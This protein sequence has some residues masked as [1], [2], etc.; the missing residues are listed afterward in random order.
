MGKLGKLPIFVI[1]L[2]AVV[3]IGGLSFGAHKMLIVPKKETLAAKEKEL[4]DLE[5]K[6][7]QLDSVKRQLAEVEQKWM[8]ANRDLQHIMETR[9]IPLSFAMP[10]E[11][12]LTI[13]YELRH[14][15]GPVLTQW[16]ES[17]GCEI[18]SGASLPAPPGSPPPPPPTGFV[19]IADNLSITVRGTLEQLE[20]LY[21]SLNQC[22]RILTVKGLS[23]K[24]EG[25]AMSATVPLTVYL[26][27]EVPPG[28][29]A[30][31]AAAPGAPGMMGPGMPGAPAM[32]G[33][34][35]APGGPA[36]GPPGPGE[37]GPR[38]EGAPAGPRLRRGAEGGEE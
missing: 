35:E 37:A 28:A 19:T 11:A 14:D 4:S 33:G 10:I 20:T 1:P 32:P 7:R 3:L 13:A 31:A 34:P 23:M 12:M 5:T 24:A 16:I 38:E 6:A 2:V 8:Q 30:A 36:A 15:L 22:P 18:V 21:K 9:S 29:A 27:A 17:T 25:T 26:L